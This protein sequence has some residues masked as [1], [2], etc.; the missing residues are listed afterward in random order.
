MPR[1]PVL[2]REG[3]I[4]RTP[5]YLVGVFY[6]N[7]L[8]S[9]VQPLNIS[10]QRDIRKTIDCWMQCSY[11]FTSFGNPEVEPKTAWDR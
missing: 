4:H 1:S 6:Y 7:Q 3:A 9:D 8:S 10:K 2:E 5:A 11:H